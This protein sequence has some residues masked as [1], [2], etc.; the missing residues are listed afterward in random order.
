MKKAGIDMK[1]ILIQHENFF[2]KICSRWWYIVQGPI[3]AIAFFP[4]YRGFLA[5]I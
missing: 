1:N 3:S 2:R 5:N 4:L